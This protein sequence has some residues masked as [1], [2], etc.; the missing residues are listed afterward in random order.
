M[1]TIP[2]LAIKFATALLATLNPLGNAIIYANFV[3]KENKKDQQKIALLVSLSVLIGLVAFAIFGNLLL[4]FFGIR[5]E[6]FQIAGGIIL[7]VLG[8]RMVNGDFSMHSQLETYKLKEEKSS[9]S[10]FNK[11]FVPIVFPVLLGPGSITT[12]IIYEAKLKASLNDF[13]LS[14][15]VITLVSLLVLIS[16]LT[17]QKLEDA[18]S[19]NI[20]QLSEKI[21]GL[22]LC[23]LSV[24]F[25][26]NGLKGFCS[27]FS[28]V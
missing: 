11:L 5:I 16:L 8:L 4:D 26:L 24:Q 17:V 14:L 1:F 2:V 27:G 25:V 18:I 6:S 10:K 23:A 21:F 12:V 13:F 7:F 15:L 28:L 9:F 20:W 19:N 3:N 22:L